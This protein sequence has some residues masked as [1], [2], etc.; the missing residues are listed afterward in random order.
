MSLCLLTNPRLVVVLTLPKLV[1]ALIPLGAG[2]RAPS[3]A[4]VLSD[5][6]WVLIGPTMQRPTVLMLVLSS[7][8]LSVHIPVECMAGCLFRE[9]SRT[10]LVV[11]LVCR[12]NRL[13]RNLAVNIA[14]L[15]K[16]GRLVEVLLIRGLSN[17]AG[18]VRLKSL[19]ETFLMLQ[20]PMT[21]IPCR[22]LTL[23]TAPSLA[24]SRR[25]LM[26]KLGPPLM[27]M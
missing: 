21:C 9:T 3:A 26:L 24:L 1:T 19:R 4:P 11:E 12:L 13:G 6:L 16:L 20:W 10:Y 18:A 14:V 17:M 23:R 15:L 7:A 25:V 8:F 2:I 22:L 5:V 27:H